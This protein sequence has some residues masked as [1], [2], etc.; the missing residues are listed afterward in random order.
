[1]TFSFGVPGIVFSILILFLV[2]NY[3]T[4]PSSYSSLLSNLTHF[5]F[6]FV[7]VSTIAFHFLKVS[8]TLDLL[9]KK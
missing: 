7:S 8:N 4:H 6:K 5:N 2:Q 1:M 3:L 9:F